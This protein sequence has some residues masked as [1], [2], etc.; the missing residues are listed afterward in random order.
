MAP[1][2]PCRR[3]RREK[4]TPQEV[5]ERYHR[6]IF[7]DW[8]RLGITFDLFTHTDTENHHAIAQRC[9]A[10]CTSRGCSSSAKEKQLYD[11]QAEQFLADRYVEGT[12]PHCGFEGARGDQCDN[13]GRT[14]D[15]IE[16]LNPRSKLT[17]T[18]PRR[19]RDRS[20][21]SST[22]PPTRRACRRT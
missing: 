11:E 13:C 19:A 17:G 21:F 15:A 8:Q 14:L 1:R 20:T 18:D 22:C 3:G 5:F 9:A 10:S 7:D 4:R 6:R 2:S 12:C 16:L